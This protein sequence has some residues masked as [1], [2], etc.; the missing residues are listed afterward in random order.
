MEKDQYAGMHMKS[1]QK[2]KRKI[3]VLALIVIGIGLISLYSVW[4]IIAPKWELSVATDRVIYELGEEVQITVSIKNLGFIDHSFTTVVGDPVVIE[5]LNYEGQHDPRIWSTLTPQNLGSP[6]LRDFTLSSHQ[7]LERTFIWNQTWVRWP[8]KN[9][10]VE[11]PPQPGMY[12]IAAFIANPEEISVEY[13]SAYSF[14]RAKTSILIENPW[15][16]LT[17]LA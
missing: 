1:L 7:S 11:R 17:V 4:V 15:A 9:V 12:W 8:E 13:E 3:I 2:S 10:S 16:N 5:I 6:A 14:L